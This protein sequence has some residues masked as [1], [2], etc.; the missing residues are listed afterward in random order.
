MAAA[1]WTPPATAAT[2]QQRK[3]LC[4]LVRQA[5]RRSVQRVDSSERLAQ[6]SFARIQPVSFQTDEV[7]RIEGAVELRQHIDATESEESAKA[8]PYYSQLSSLTSLGHGL[9]LPVS[10]SDLRLSRKTAHFVLQ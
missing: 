6:R 1:Q 7:A 9:P 10:R 4:S 3:S 2:G 8:K 5:G